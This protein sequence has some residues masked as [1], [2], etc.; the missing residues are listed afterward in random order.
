MS[1]RFKRCLQD[2]FFIIP[3]VFNKWKSLD[4]GNNNYGAKTVFADANFEMPCKAG[5][6]V[7][8][9]RSIQS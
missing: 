9:D 4:C 3:D 8:Y 6:I 5:D 1:V 2:I 7:T